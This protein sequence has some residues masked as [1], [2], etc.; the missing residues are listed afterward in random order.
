M[1]MK[2]YCIVVLLVSHCLWCG[3]GLYA[4][5]QSRP[6]RTKARSGSPADSTESAN[7]RP[8]HFENAER[9]FKKRNFLESIQEYKLSLEDYPENEAA[10][11]GMA[12]AQAE[13][14]LMQEA[15]Q[16]YKAALKINPKLWEAET[17]LGMLLLK[18]QRFDEALPHFKKAQEL[19]SQSFHISFFSAKV[20]ESLGRF[21]E[22]TE[23]YKQA[24]SLA[25]NAAEK[26]EVHLSMGQIYLKTRSWPDAEKHLVA[27]RE[28]QSDTTAL[29]VEL[30]QLYLQTGDNSRCVALL[31][32]LAE[33]LTDNA[34]IQEL[35]GRAY[36][37]TG[38]LDKASRS[39]EL[40]LT[41][42][43]DSGRRQ[44]ISLQ[45]AQV[46]QELGETEK[47]IQVLQP[48]AGNS[49]DSKLHFHLGTLQLQH[50]NFDAALQSFLRALQLDPRCADCYSNLGS[51]FMLQE[52]YPEAIQA[53]TQFKAARPEIAGTYFYLGIAFDK[54]NDVE[55]AFAHYQKFLELDQGKSDKQGFQ[56]R[57]RMKV[58][59]KRIK[60]R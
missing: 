36:T 46:Y 4:Q 25:Q 54:L 11:F 7:D 53:F 14:G 59:E 35:L 34:D 33:R 49:T 22:A 9:L 58:L 51:I 2:G 18:Q 28:Y 44:N 6:S 50:R 57:E 15:E 21:P 30:A 10:L 45:L 24:L 38:S 52:K 20:L 19:N 5:S 8:S 29:D 32:P 37:R 39:L 42:Q 12:L 31:Q 43:A 56:A 26:L 27:A 16:S 3:F 1:K 48:V 55:N 13:A 60:K 47:A 17:N 23:H 40:A 41:H